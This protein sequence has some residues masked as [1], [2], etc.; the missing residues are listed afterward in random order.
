MFVNDNWT[1]D[2]TAQF[3]LV[4]QSGAI[5]FYP[6]LVILN[7]TAGDLLKCVN[8]DADGLLEFSEFPLQALPMAEFFDK[9]KGLAVR[10]YLRLDPD[11]QPIKVRDLFLSLAKEAKG[12][13]VTAYD[14]F[15][16]D[17][18]QAILLEAFEGKPHH[19]NP[20][21]VAV[22]NLIQER[23]KDHRDGDGLM[24]SD[25][26]TY[27]DNSPFFFVVWLSHFFGL[28]DTFKVLGMLEQLAECSFP[29]RH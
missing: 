24:K 10:E 14:Y 28:G 5:S 8:I 9:S 23:W 16:R 19:T 4:S 11:F 2:L 22:H 25:G 12:E 29:P 7:S 20:V 13:P 21:E 3:R 18:V 1:E 15:S 17:D 6:F 26:I 27:T